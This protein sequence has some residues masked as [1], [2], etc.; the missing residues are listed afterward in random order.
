MN[1]SVFGKTIEN[2][3]KRV[4]VKLVT[5]W[6]GRFGAEAYISMPNFNSCTIFDDNLVAIQMDQLEVVIDKPIYIGQAVLDISKVVLYDFHYKFMKTTLGES[7]KLL[8]TDTDSLIYDIKCDDV[9]EFMKENL[10]RFDTSDYPPDNQY[11]LPCVNKKIPGLMKDE[12]NGRRP[13]EFLGLK[14]KEYCI[15]VGSEDFAKK[16]KGVQTSVVQNEINSD[17]YR[18]VLFN[19]TEHYRKQCKITN[20]QHK[21]YTET[22][23]KKALSPS[24]DK[25]YIIPNSTDTLPWGHKDIKKLCEKC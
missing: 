3:R 7:C 9:Y 20:K 25:R 14:S 18:D 15:V 21:I 24:D 1:N 8:Y 22:S 2:V 10:N 23:M 17:D 19:S 16:S 13:S 5:Q 6:Y 12:C 11:G 4:H